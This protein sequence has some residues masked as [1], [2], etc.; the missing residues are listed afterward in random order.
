MR[1]VDPMTS[2]QTR[3]T[4]SFDHERLI[5]VDEQD[6][7]VGC[8]SKVAVHLEGA[9][10]R[11]FSIFLFAGPDRVLLHRRSLDK[12]LWPGFWTN[13]CCSHPREGESYPGAATRRLREELGVA[14]DLAWLYQF[15]YRADY[16]DIGTEHE[17]C[18]VMAGNVSESVA[19]RPHPEEVMEWGWFDCKRV[20]RWVAA[21]PGSFTPWFKLEWSRLR[22]DLRPVIELLC[23]DGPASAAAAVA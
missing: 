22:G 2:P 18:A 19:V 6:R 9:L 17:L 20:D 12:P 21:S 3:N 1:P 4:V 10:H 23:S 11:A 16:R 8:D 14:A 7:V 13:S 5:L 15:R